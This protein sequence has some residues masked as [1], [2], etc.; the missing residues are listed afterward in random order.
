MPL[1]SYKIIDK[2]GHIKRREGFFDSAVMIEDMTEFSK[3]TLLSS[4]QIRLK[5]YAKLCKADALQLLQTL[6]TLLGAGLSLLTALESVGQGEGSRR[7]K[8]AL[9][10]M[11]H[12]LNEG[13]DFAESLNKLQVYP[14]FI[15]DLIRLGLKT[16]KLPESLEKAQTLLYEELERDKELRKSIFYPMILLCIMLG[17][18]ILFTQLLLP[19]ISLY[20]QELGIQD[21]PFVTKALMTTSHFLESHSG[22]LLYVVL[23]F[24]GIL[25]GFQ[26]LAWLQRHLTPLFL[27][28]PFW[29]RFYKRKHQN[30]WLFYISHLYASG[31]DFKS[32]LDFTAASFQNAFMRDVL[33]RAHQSVYKGTSLL[34]TLTHTGIFSGVTLSLIQAGAETGDIAGACGKAYKIEEARQKST[35]TLF[36]KVLEPALLLLMGLVLLWIVLAV[37]TPIYDHL[38]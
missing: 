30:Q 6:S 27:S 9:R 16:S 13:N 36:L 35:Q 26:K 3:E 28:I 8:R 29:G 12:S 34:N 24:G 33:R 37:I 23:I 4:K 10:M 5:G 21:F 31:M 15:I 7:F 38:V 18:I 19:E 25:A 17:M 32:A 11:K 22:I 14:D 2:D 20:L 1:Y